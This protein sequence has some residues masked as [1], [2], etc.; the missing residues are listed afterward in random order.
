MSYSI[1]VAFT[2]KEARDHAF[3]T[4][5][6]SWDEIKEGHPAWRDLVP[7]KENGLKYPP[8]TSLPLLGF[9]VQGEIL[10]SDVC[11]FLA[12]KSDYRKNGKPVMFF[13]D[14]L[15]FLEVGSYIDGKICVT[16]EG[17]RLRSEDPLLTRIGAAVLGLTGE[18]R[19]TRDVITLLNERWS[20][21]PH[22]AKAA[23]VN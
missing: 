3:D 21:S 12:L 18:R 13:D 7:Q 11:S 1:S 23:K 17:Y 10:S 5:M 4:L 16:E 6:A 20:A 22:Q 2:S 19:K 9:N 15:N 14:E 8:D